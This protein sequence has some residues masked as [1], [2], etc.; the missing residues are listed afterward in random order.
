MSFGGG[1]FEMTVAGV[2]GVPSGTGIIYPSIKNEISKPRGLPPGKC[3]GQYAVGQQTTN[4]LGGAG[5]AIYLGIRV[6]MYY[7]Q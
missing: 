7:D 5:A 3:F 4:A 6:Y 1:C 2:N